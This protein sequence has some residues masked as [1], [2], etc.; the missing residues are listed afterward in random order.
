MPVFF[1]MSMNGF[2]VA[3]SVAGALAYFPHRAGSASSL[4]GAMHYGSGIFSAALVS[5][6]SDGT[7][8]G[9]ALVMGGAGIG[10]LAVALI[11]TTNDGPR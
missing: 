8:R 1:Y 9:M 3:N 10:S 2:I 7:P 6:L 4:L 11:S 5:W